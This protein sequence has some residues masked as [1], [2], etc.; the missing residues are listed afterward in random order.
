MMSDELHRS[1]G[2]LEGMLSEVLRNQ[3]D[4]KETFEKHDTRLRHIEGNYMKGVG[5]VTAISFGVTYFWDIIKH[6]LFGK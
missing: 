6:G 3:E 1:L 4:F 2:K 5:I